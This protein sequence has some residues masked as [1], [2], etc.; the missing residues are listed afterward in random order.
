MGESCRGTRSPSVWIGVLA[1]AAAL[2]SVD[3]QARITRIEVTSTESPTFG[4][5]AWPDVGQYEKI[6]GV[7]H[8]EVDPRDPRNAVITDIK[9]APR[10]ARGKVEYSFDFYILNPIDLKTGNDNLMNEPPTRGR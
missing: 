3:A 7:A 4:G 6:V 10:N 1:T 9:L 2:T 5:Y 8:G